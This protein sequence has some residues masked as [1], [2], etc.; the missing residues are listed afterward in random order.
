M[1][2]CY[3]NVIKSVSLKRFSCIFGKIVLLLLGRY[4]E[5]K[6]KKMTRL[7]Q[8]FTLKRNRIKYF[9]VITQDGRN[10]VGSSAICFQ[11]ISIF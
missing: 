10:S 2:K 6:S 5:K 3:E 11:Q 9:K 1:Q 4:L 8:F 7:F